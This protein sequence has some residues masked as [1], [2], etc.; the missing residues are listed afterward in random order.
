MKNYITYILS[1]FCVSLFIVF[2]GCS[3]IYITPLIGGSYINSNIDKLQS[4]YNSYIQ[5]KKESSST[6]LKYD[7][8]WSKLMF[9]PTIGG[10][11]GIST[12]PLFVAFSFLHTHAKQKR[13]IEFG[14]DYGREFS[15]SERRNEFLLDL[16]FGSPKID[17][18]GSFGV[19]GNNFTMSSFQVYPDGTK[20]LSS[21]YNFNGVFKQYDGGI[22]Y[23][24][25]IKI[26]P[27]K[28]VGL[29]LRYLYANDQLIGENNLLIEDNVTLTDNSRD[30]SY[31]T[32]ELPQDYREP[33]S[34]S[35]S[36]VPNFSCSYLNLSIF[37]YFYK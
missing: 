30:R 14:N 22:S 32:S 37:Y 25:G 16:G 33:L 4:S 31:G 6:N 19:N 10:Q 13:S 26:K 3:Q 1:T 9:T 2:E 36:I 12:K 17:I 23:G 27:V 7:N 20:S 15:W 24:F 5:L 34:F 28:Y 35:N 29:E 11:I 21:E 18:F 8:N